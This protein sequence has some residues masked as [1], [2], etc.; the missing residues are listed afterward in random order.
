MYQKFLYVSEK[1]RINKAIYLSSCLKPILSVRWSDGLRGSDMINIVLI[2]VLCLYWI[3]YA[4][5]YIF[6]NFY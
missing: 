2:F 6:S 1:L 3:Y 4:V 5:V